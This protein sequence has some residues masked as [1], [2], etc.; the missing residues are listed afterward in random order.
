MPSVN[1][2]MRTREAPICAVSPTLVTPRSDRYVLSMMTASRAPR[3]E[4][5]PST[6]FQGRKPP[7]STSEPMTTTSVDPPVP[8]LDVGTDD[9]DECRSARRLAPVGKRHNERDGL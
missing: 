9:D 8:V 6:T 4:T 7:S 3:P 2:E 1:P 5:S